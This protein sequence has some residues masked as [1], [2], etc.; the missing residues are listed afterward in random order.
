MEDKNQTSS[1]L[2]DIKD[3]RR[4]MERS[5]R[6]ISL[7]GLSGVAAGICA[8]IGVFIADN[9]LDN[10]FG[11]YNSRGF[12]SGDDFSKLKIRFALLAVVVFGVAFIS[13]FY[14]TWRK[15]KKQGLPIWD[16]T[17]KRLAWNMLVPLI[18][19]AIFIM[20]MLRYDVWLFVAPACL[21][22]YGLALVNA[23][24]YTLADIRYLGYC[25]IVLGLISMF[26][27]GYGLWIWAIGFGLLHII[28]GIVM[29]QK[30]ERV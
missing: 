3:I 10:Y 19:G 15:A 30:Y 6:F 2:Q 20:G 22:F 21:I 1:S 24:K 16:H 23:S 26:L 5:S 4:I 9:M 7:S 11:S 25:E 17:T 18:A 29:W 12:F 8:L 28:Y 27:P 13:S 14:L